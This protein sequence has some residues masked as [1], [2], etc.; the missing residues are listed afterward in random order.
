MMMKKRRKGVALE[1][2]DGDEGGGQEVSIV[3]KVLTY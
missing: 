2:N 3:P 1:R